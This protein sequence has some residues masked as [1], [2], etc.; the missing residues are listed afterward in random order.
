MGRKSFRLAAMGMSLLAYMAAEQAL[1]QNAPAAAPAVAAPDTATIVVTGSRISR[2]LDESP[3]PVIAIRAT[4]LQQAGSINLTDYLKTIPALVGSRDSYL[5]SGDRAPIGV[6]G[7]NLLNLRNLGVNR[8]LVLVD[9]R[10]HVSSLEGQQAVDMNA[11]PQDLIDRV[12]ISTGGASAVY[13]ADG[14]SGVVNIILKKDFAGLT[15]R[16]QAGISSRGD[17]AQRLVALTAGHNFADG[18]GNIAL[19]WEHAE[20]DSLASSQRDY[21]SGTNLVGLFPSSNTSNTYV[22][23]SGARYFDTSRQGAIDVNFDQMPDFLGSGAPFDHGTFISGQPGMGFQQGGSGTLVSDYGSDLLPRLRRDVIN[24]TAS[25]R[26]S[27]AFALHVDAKYARVH[28][29]T[30]GQPTFDYYLV[31]PGYNPYLPATVAPIAQQTGFVLLNRD[32]FD[33]GRRGEDITRE[34]IRTVVSADGAITPHLKYELSYVF[35]RTDVT[36]RLIGDRYTDRFL[37]AIDVI[38]GPNG[39]TCMANLVPGWTP[40]QPLQSR[41][42]APTTFSPGQCVPL[43]LF[44]EGQASQAAIQWITAPTVNRSRLEQHVVSGSLTGDTGAFLMLPGGPIRF[45]LGGEYRKESSDFRPDALLEQG[46]TYGNMLSRVTGNY[47][48]TEAFAEVSLPLLADMP[49]AHRLELSGGLRLSDYSTVHKTTAWKLGLNWAPDPSV[50]L[51]GTYS[52]AVRAPNISELFTPGGQTFAVIND[53]CSF[54]NLGAGTSYRA[55]N[56]QTLLTAAGVADPASFNGLTRAAGTLSGNRA[57]NEERADTWTAGF[58]LR[59]RS[60]PRFSLTADWYSISIGNAIFTAPAAQ[61]AALCVDQASLDNPYCAMLTR[62]PGAGLIGTFALSPVNA[63]RLRTSGLDVSLSY[64]LPTA[65]AGTF[66]LRLAGNYLHRLD[67]TAAP[68]ADPLVLA[69]QG[70]GAPAPRYQATADLGWSLGRFTANWRLSYF[71]KTDRFAAATMASN[72]TITAPEY[73]QYKARFVHDLY[74]ASDVTDAF[75]IYGGVNN[76]FDQK[77]DIATLG[78]SIQSPTYPVSAVGRYLYVGARVK[79]GELFQ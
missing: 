61:A 72:P 34:T 45:A 57:L 62:I 75:Q 49:F 76:L 52:V 25:F 63:A 48:V 68:G 69:G 38:Q 27:D 24:G 14:V 26:A 71:S 73:R 37:A 3:N 17:A 46:L 77:P 66:N 31:I 33:L 30:L 28:S 35:G 23:V 70:G 64:A 1:A 50:V 32:N 13:G 56:C 20:E 2:R 39:P 7:L 55:A 6:S 18:R 44:G 74:L 58:V 59:P 42:V 54:Y 78:D 15:G 41:V 22:P 11:I 40:F 29:T 51:R 4:D 79:L 5:N 21:L 36:N 67:L 47:D 9:G 16:A 53:P 10:R 43:N 8:T 19:A 65:R 60:L 12:E